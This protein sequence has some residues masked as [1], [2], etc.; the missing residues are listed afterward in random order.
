MIQ[1]CKDRDKD[2]R[3]KLLA[4]SNIPSIL[5]VSWTRMILVHPLKAVITFWWCVIGLWFG[6]VLGYPSRC[7]IMTCTGDSPEIPSFVEMTSSLDK[8]L[9]VT[10]AWIKCQSDVNLSQSLLRRCISTC[11]VNPS[12]RPAWLTANAAHPLVKSAWLICRKWTCHQMETYVM[13]INFT[14]QLQQQ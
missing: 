10:H 11:P 7:L 2:F 5:I 1:S 12:G 4:S 3:T 14:R 6:L 9:G 13:V 8:T